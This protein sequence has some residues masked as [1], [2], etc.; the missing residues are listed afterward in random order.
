MP[1]H[2]RARAKDSRPFETTEEMT[3]SLLSTTD[4][5]VE[6]R[7]SWTRSPTTSSP[8]SMAAR[9]AGKTR[10][11]TMALGED[12]SG[13]LVIGRPRRTAKTSSWMVGFQTGGRIRV[14]RAK[15]PSASTGERRDGKVS[16]RTFETRDPDRLTF[17]TERVSL[18]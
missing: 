11:Q 5:L 15:P 1:P 12:S 13:G 14:R 10:E 9:I 8:P 16:S 2:E 4:E 18:W 17:A 6:T 7:V 3:E